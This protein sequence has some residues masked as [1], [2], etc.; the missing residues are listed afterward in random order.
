MSRATANGP[1]SGV[2]AG[3]SLSIRRGR[4]GLNLERCGGVD[5]NV[6]RAFEAG[7][8]DRAPSAIEARA[9]DHDGRDRVELQ[10][11]A[12]QRVGRQKLRDREGHGHRREGARYHIGKN[13]VEETGRPAARAASRLE[14]TA[15]MVHPPFV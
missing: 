15:S 3:F 8:A 1:S 14:R 7:E 11:V 2:P 4:K 5:R 9:P 10:H 6:P 13:A 12:H